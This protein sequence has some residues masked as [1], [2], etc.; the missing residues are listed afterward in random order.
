MACIFI[1]SVIKGV[2]NMV[3]KSYCGTIDEIKQQMEEDSI[4]WKNNPDIA[5]MEAC[6]KSYKDTLRK[7]ND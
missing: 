2:N 5:V 6:E 7:A 3:M 1:E 4:D